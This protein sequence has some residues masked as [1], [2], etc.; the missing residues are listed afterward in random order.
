MDYHRAYALIKDLDEKMDE[1][2]SGCITHST[3]IMLYTQTKAIITA[4]TAFTYEKARE[5]DEQE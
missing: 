2:V 1:Q 4:L 3:E 5:K